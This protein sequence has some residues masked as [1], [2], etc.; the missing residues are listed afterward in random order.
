MRLKYSEGSKKLPSEIRPVG[1]LSFTR[2]ATNMYDL[3]FHHTK[4][5]SGKYQENAFCQCKVEM[6]PNLQSRDVPIGK[7]G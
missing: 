1:P 4:Q 2:L 3:L 5:V 6:S 7:G